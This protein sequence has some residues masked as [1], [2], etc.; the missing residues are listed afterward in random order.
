MQHVPLLGAAVVF[1]AAGFLVAD[2]LTALA[3]FLTGAWQSTR[4][5]RERKRAVS[6]K[7]SAKCVMDVY[8]ASSSA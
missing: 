2:F 8:T 4:A 6:Q 1:F 5:I 3:L 7:V